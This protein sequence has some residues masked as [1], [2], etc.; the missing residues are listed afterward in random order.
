MLV[1][2]F[3]Y[4]EFILYLF[5]L[6]QASAAGFNKIWK[7]KLTRHEVPKFFD[8]CDDQVTIG[9]IGNRVL[10][11]SLCL[12]IGNTKEVHVLGT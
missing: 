7:K 11:N 9:N 3:S 8:I 1:S 2:D 12:Q 10:Q 5:H 4:C 6:F